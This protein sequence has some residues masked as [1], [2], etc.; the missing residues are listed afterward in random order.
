MCK[1]KVLMAIKHV[2]KVIPQTTLDYTKNLNRLK[3]DF[4]VHG[5]DWRRV[6]ASTRGKVIKTIMV[7]NFN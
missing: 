3:P 5:K 2:K 6:Q 1:E 4:V 7:G